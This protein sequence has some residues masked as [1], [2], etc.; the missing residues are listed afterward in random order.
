MN[1][2][3]KIEKIKE[4]IVKKTKPLSVFIY[5][6]YVTQDFLPGVSD[7]EIGVIKKGSRPVFKTLKK[8][9]NKYSTNS[10]NFRIYSYHLEDL[11]RHKIDSPFTDTIFLRRLILS[12]KTIW[13]HSIIESIPLPFIDLIDIYR[14]AC[15]STAMALS[16]LF[17]VRIGNS[18]EASERVSKACLFA[19]ACLEYLNKE[20]PVTFKDILESSKS[21]KLN[22]KQKKLIKFAYNLRIGKKNPRQEEL[23]TFIY[24]T[25][26]YCN[27]TIEERIKRDLRRGNRIVL[28]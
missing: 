9:A 27:G 5:G 18:E 1:L 19:T 25:I 14:E 6:S 13:G 28:R 8:I 15:F 2:K 7:V 22:Q 21:L 23:F 12:S 10:T 17:M 3:R 11:K 20:F 4:E 26:R 16:A 24:E